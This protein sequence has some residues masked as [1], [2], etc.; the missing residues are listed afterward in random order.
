MSLDVINEN[1]ATFEPADTYIIYLNNKTINED[2]VLDLDVPKNKNLLIVLSNVVVLGRFGI[3]VLTD[4]Q[5]DDE[6][7]HTD[8]IFNNIMVQYSNNIDDYAGDDGHTKLFNDALAASQ[9]LNADRTL[10]LYYPINDNDELDARLIMSI[11][12][13][14]NAVITAKVGQINDLVIPNGV[15]TVI[16]I[17]AD[18]DIPFVDIT[19]AR[20]SYLDT[21][22]PPSETAECPARISSTATGIIITFLAI[23]S[24]CTLSIFIYLVLP[25]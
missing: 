9:N 21:V 16:A 10:A 25:N 18:N 22:C 4:I 2:F 8:E 12:Q 14:S 19:L 6:Q 1:I 23:L 5:T 15:A 17:K 24:L 13:N 7:M 3:H 20:N 11:D